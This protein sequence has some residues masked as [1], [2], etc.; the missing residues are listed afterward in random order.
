MPRVDDP[1][2]RPL[3]SPVP[4]RLA[5][6]VAFLLIRCDAEPD[7]D[8]GTATGERPDGVPF[9]AKTV[10]VTLDGVPVSNATVIQGGGEARWLTGPDGLAEVIVDTS[11]RG[12]WHLVASHP[13]A[14]TQ[15]RAGS[16]PIAIDEPNPIVIALTS[17]APGDNEAYVFQHPGTPQLWEST[18]YC[19]HC[20]GTMTDGWYTSAHRSSASNPAVQ[21][22]YIGTATAART[23]AACDV[24]GGRWAK[25]PAPGTGET[26]MR[27]FLGQGVLPDLNPAGTAADQR[28][29]GA[30][31][32]CH[33]PG[34]DG[35]AGG[36]DLLD[37]VGVAYDYG[38]HCDVCHKI[39]SVDMNASAGVAGRLRLQRP[40]EPALTQP[41]LPLSFGPY[42][43][44]PTAAM[45]SVPRDHF[46][47]SEFCGGCH[48]LEQTA[49]LP[50]QDIDPIRWPTRQIPIHS[51]Y[52]EWRDDYA[53]PEVTCSQCHMTVAFDVTNSGD[54]QL[55]EQTNPN[56]VP[57]PVVGWERPVGEV[58]THEWKGPRARDW[59]ALDAVL[60]VDLE[61]FEQDDGLWVHATVE[62]VGAGH[63]VPT[64]EPMRS[65]VLSVTASCD[66][67]PLPATGGDVVPD[68]GGAR[69]HKTAGEDWTRWPTARRGDVVRVVRRHAEWHDYVGH[70]PFGDGR[71]AAPEK[72]MPRE[73]YVGQA[74]V[75]FVG[76]DGRVGFDRSLPPGDVA[77]LGDAH[78]GR[79]PGDHSPTALAGAPG[80]GFARVLTDAEGHRMVP[81]F[82]AT[83]VESDNR[84]L[85]RQP[86]TSR[87]RFAG[88][89]DE[90]VI[91]ARAALR[92]FPRDLAHQ[93]G[94]IEREVVLV[95]LRREPERNGRRRPPLREPATSAHKKT[96]E[97]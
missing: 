4:W 15:V 2:C 12:E 42:Y 26:A 85:P 14:R 40:S 92:A 62:N 51:T 72:G 76:A 28:R 41:W 18:E 81:H 78:P 20:H 88:G 66:G 36:R 69:A 64:G 67:E 5:L 34:I 50:G 46:R 19:S 7:P 55:I 89:C 10:L 71:F 6:V 93:R 60:R 21:D 9:F 75:V 54:L 97:G 77:Y 70:G 39:E 84:L 90:P 32:D 45:G 83:D 17:V 48:E 79:T 87:H 65:V 47:R 58:R 23:P 95:D 91:R 82:V 30:C 16:K 94:W 43:D 24:I 53:R 86:W 13:H 74:Q 1:L 52:R 11:I 8:P 73:G 49:L 33:A 31:A 25:G 35:R 38:I 80:F 27:C 3:R 29:F 61:T 96:A 57:G 56:V 68:F 37:A 44:V 22:L 59:P 63:A